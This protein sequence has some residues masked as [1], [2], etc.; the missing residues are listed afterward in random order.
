[1]QVVPSPLR[2]SSNRRL[3]K[4]HRLPATPTTMSQRQC[5]GIPAVFAGFAAL[6]TPDPSAAKE[7]ERCIGAGFKG[8]I[9]LGRQKFSVHAVDDDLAPLSGLSLSPELQQVPSL[10]LEQAALDCGGT[11]P[12]QQESCQPQD[13]FSLDSRLR[14]VI[15]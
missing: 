6:P 4:P 8:A 14:I 10:D 5:A 3:V 12:P 1:M 2:A 11:A 7:L 13:E 15:R 9:V